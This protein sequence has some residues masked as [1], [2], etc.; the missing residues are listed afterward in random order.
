MS[1]SQKKYIYTNK[2]EMGRLDEQQ[3]EW[4]TLCLKIQD[5]ADVAEGIRILRGEESLGKIRCIQLY[6]VFFVYTCSF[7]SCFPHKLK[8]TLICTSAYVL[9]PGNN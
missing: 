1:Q 8:L 7:V 3:K 6:V 4:P 9:I 5:P 2:K